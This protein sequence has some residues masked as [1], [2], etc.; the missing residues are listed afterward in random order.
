[1]NC[2]KKTKRTF[3]NIFEIFSCDNCESYYK[4][5]YIYI[6][7]NKIRIFEYNSECINKE[8]INKY[9]RL[10][11]KDVIT[12]QINYEFLVLTKKEYKKIFDYLPLFMKEKND[13]F[14]VLL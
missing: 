8:T 3:L 11:L 6:G 7:L 5:Y 13:L 10:I 9:Y 1:M 4:N 12:N 14:I 2:L